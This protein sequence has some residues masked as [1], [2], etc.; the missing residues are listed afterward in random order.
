M[1]LH[2]RIFSIM[3][4]FETEET[5]EQ[6]KAQVNNRPTFLK[7]L[8][9][10]TF[11]STGLGL[12][13]SL[14]LPSV[15]D[16]LVELLKAT[17]SYNESEMAEAIGLIQA[18]GL[19]YFYTFMLYGI[20]LTGAIFMWRLKKSGFHLYAAANLGMYFLPMVYLHIPF[21]IFGLL[22]TLGFIGM[23]GTHL[24]LMK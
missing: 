24:R 10:L 3:E 5:V 1:F 8:C 16:A 23:Y 13:T 15:A 9:I 20:S 7:V 6:E 19:Y 18:G 14:L 21:N 12:L 17:P 4:N 22:I 2:L 11:I